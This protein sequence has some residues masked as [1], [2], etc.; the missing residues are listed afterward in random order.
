LAIERAIVHFGCGDIQ[1]GLARGA[2]VERERFRAAAPL[3]RRR[4]IAQVRKEMFHRAE[5]ITAES[6][7][8]PVGPPERTAVEHAREKCMRQNP[9]P[10][11][12]R[13][14]RRGGT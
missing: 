7:A 12:R 6:P 13:G 10:G 3:F 14:R 11:H 9:A 8:R 4:A 2:G 5:Q 1:P